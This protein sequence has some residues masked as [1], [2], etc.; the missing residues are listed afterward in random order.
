MDHHPTIAKPKWRIARVSRLPV[1][2]DGDIVKAQVE[3]LE[4]MTVGFSASRINRE[5]FTTHAFLTLTL[6]GQHTLAFSYMTTDRNTERVTLHNTAHAMMPEALREV[7]PKPVLKADLDDFCL[8]LWETYNSQFQATLVE[9][10]PEWNIEWYC[11]PLV[12]KDAATILFAPRGGGKSQV[13]MTAAVSINSGI[14]NIWG[15]MMSAPVLYVNLER[16]EA[17]MRRRL[18]RINLAMG[19]SAREP[20]LMLNARGRSL[21][22][23]YEAGRSIVA[24]E[25]VE[26]VVLDSISRT[27]VGNLN[28]NEPGN[29]V[30]DML[31]ALSPTWLAI[32]HQTTPEG[33]KAK[34]FGSQMYENAA[35]IVTR[36]TSQEEDGKLGVALEIVKANDTKLG[37]R[38]FLKYEFNG[39]GVESIKKTDLTEFPELDTWVPS[40]RQKIKTFIYENG[41]RGTNKEISEGT[42][43]DPSNVS[44]LLKGKEFYKLDREGRE[45]PYGVME[46]ELEEQRW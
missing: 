41:G 8:K 26:V 4:G 7:Y 12:M 14:S 33:G 19:L 2:L 1:A 37:Q 45:Q 10:E 38:H 39:T 25:G 5:K 18:G 30:C 31:S 23:I 20:L 40:N 11:P 6:N 3:P 13:A 24:Q 22:N 34:V 46:T 32:A 17:S 29:K 36:L 16:S 28:D 15:P 42:G 44:K 21:D 27:Q 35:D 9:G 43:I